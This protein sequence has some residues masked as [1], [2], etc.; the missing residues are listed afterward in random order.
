MQEKIDFIN[1]ELLALVKKI[2]PDIRQLN[3]SFDSGC[4]RE[5]CHVIFKGN[6]KMHVDITADSLL[7][8]TKDVL[9]AV[10]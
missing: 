10:E 4:G 1:N 8:I 6:Y 9:R 2:N 5:I 7:A 3:Y